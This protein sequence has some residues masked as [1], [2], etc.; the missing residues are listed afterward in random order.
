MCIIFIIAV[1]WMIKQI[2]NVVVESI[3]KMI[4]P[5]VNF[6]K[7]AAIASLIN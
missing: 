5:I 2:C 3:D 6:N 4:T 1:G 7:I